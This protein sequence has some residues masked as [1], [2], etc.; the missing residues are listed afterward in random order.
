MRYTFVITTG[1]CSRYCVCY[2]YRLL[3]YCS[4]YCVFDLGPVE[5]PTSTEL[6]QFLN[7]QLFKHPADV[8]NSILVTTKILLLKIPLNKF[9]ENETQ[10]CNKI[11]CE[12][13][14]WKCHVESH[15]STACLCRSQPAYD[16]FQRGTEIIIIII[17]RNVTWIWGGFHIIKV[18]PLMYPL[19]L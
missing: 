14:G 16:T 15:Y 6:Q 8:G 17:C 11:M 9:L 7:I 19:I 4:R 13:C 5:Q 2:N 3:Q 1:Y 10:L 18:K 12:L